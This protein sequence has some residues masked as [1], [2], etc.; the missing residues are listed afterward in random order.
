M[1]KK[2]KRRTPAQLAADAMR[3]GR[4]PLGDAAK[5]E[6]VRIRVTK[7]ELAF[8]KRRAREQGMGVASLLRRGGGLKA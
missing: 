2:K 6:V 4:P 1:G 5:T 3:T 7:K 8:L